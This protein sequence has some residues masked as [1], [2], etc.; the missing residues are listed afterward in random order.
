MKT[1][2]NDG[3]SKGITVGTMEMGVASRFLARLA[4]ATILVGLMLSLAACGGDSEAGEA[5][6][7]PETS[8][9]P[10]APGTELVDSQ[11]DDD[12]FAG[13]YESSNAVGSVYRSTTATD[14]VT[15][16]YSEGIVAE[17]WDVVSSG[18][19]ATAHIV[20]ATK[21]DRV[22]LITIMDAETYRLAPGLGG[23]ED[24]GLTVEN[25]QDGETIIAVM[26]FTC[27]EDDISGCFAIG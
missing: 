9:I 18:P 22:A 3:R 15:S 23:L 11:R 25:V 12:A 1:P 10:L 17:G 19:L 26:E 4:L 21:D 8:G 20:S 14:D 16:F 2:R 24:F 27:E 13:L 5:S 6:E 7:K